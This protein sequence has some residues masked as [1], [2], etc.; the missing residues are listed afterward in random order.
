MN[1]ANWRSFFSSRSKKIF[2]KAQSHQRYFFRLIGRFRFLEF[3]WSRRRRSLHGWQTR[4]WYRRTARECLSASNLSS[5][6]PHHW[7]LFSQIVPNLPQPGDRFSSADD[8]LV[9]CYVALLPVYGNGA[10]LA[11]T[12]SITIECSRSQY[13]PGSDR[14]GRCNWRIGAVTDEKTKEVVVSAQLSRLLHNHG[15][16]AGIIKDP[17][18]RPTVKHPLVRRALGLFPLEPH[19]KTQVSFSLLSLV[20]SLIRW[21][22]FRFR[23]TIRLPRNSTNNLRR[24]SSTLLTNSTRLRSR[25]TLHTLHSSRTLLPTFNR[26]RKSQTL[27][28]TLIT[29]K[30]HSLRPLPPPLPI[31]LTASRCLNLTLIPLSL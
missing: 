20:R 8:L 30:T 7:S 11:K 13:K 3:F 16:S 19:N 18:Y 15:R 27:L 28:I 14:N 23:M 9:A 5:T 24:N 31:P 22:A 1:S 17:N 21:S 2:C 26:I 25:S 29:L 6:C 10:S 12:K 4:V